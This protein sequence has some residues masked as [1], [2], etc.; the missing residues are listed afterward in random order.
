MEI[1]YKET[2]AERLV[3]KA[4]L[5]ARISGEL[6]SPDG[7][8]VSRV[9]SAMPKIQLGAVRTGNG[10][11]SFEG[12]INVSVNA[13]DTSDELFSYSS[14]AS[15]KQT[16]E[17][18]EADATMRSE[19]ESSI[20]NITLSPAQSGANMDADVDFDIRVIS[21]VPVK[22]CSGAKDIDDIEI[23]TCP[24]SAFF[25]RPLGNETL[26]LREEITVDEPVRVISSESLVTI[27]DLT[28]D[29]N[30]TVVSG[31]ITVSAVVADISGR[32]MQIVKQI[33]FRERLSIS[34]DRDNVFCSS[35]NNTVYLRS[36]G[37]DFP[38]IAVE[39]Q[40][41]LDLYAIEESR[42]ELPL[43]LFS[44]TA[45]IKAINERVT[46]YNDRGCSGIQTT[47]K[48][49]LSMP[50]TVSS[51]KEVLF[52][53]ALPVITE[54]YPERGSTVVNGVLA[55]TVAF[56]NEYGMKDSFRIDTDF[57]AE[58]PSPISAELPLIGAEC[59]AS[60][61]M[62][63]ERNVQVQYSLSVKE[64]MITQEEFTIVTSLEECEACEQESCIM[65]LFA[66]EGDDVF[67]IAKRY[68]VPCENIRKLNPEISEPF[69]D[70]DKL[71]LMI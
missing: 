61:V 4:D 59:I 57:S 25:K 36:L 62:I 2:A 10:E 46:L 52:A 65:I 50:E 34:F 66:S 39:A 54:V 23:K 48:E 64:E 13:V 45:G 69:R 7:R 11:V 18:P 53:S 67:D 24:V 1:I 63:D 43:D 19:I 51:V 30:G 44:P 21:S 26:R 20:R 9:L 71:L 56:I 17:C 40:I 60:A 42:S 33:P 35:T 68:S 6:P 32:V 15:F 58:V 5:A 70:G 14:G 22:A 31:S 16:V 3:T 47:I 28:G 38:M 12:R 29:G 41:G 55:T 8:T 49:T 37:D 27:K